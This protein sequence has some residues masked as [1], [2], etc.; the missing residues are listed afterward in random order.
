[1]LFELVKQRVYGASQFVL[2]ELDAEDVGGVDYGCGVD[3][4]TA[5]RRARNVHIDWDNSSEY[6]FDSSCGLGMLLTSIDDLLGAHRRA[7]VSYDRGD[8][9]NST[10]ATDNVSDGQQ[11]QAGWN[12]ANIDKHLAYT[13]DVFYKVKTI[14]YRE[15]QNPVLSVG[16]E[17]AFIPS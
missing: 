2:G 3:V 8:I 1:M 10:L 14:Q 17:G 9:R 11:H 12:G 5:V 13:C 4:W 7:I 15:Y 16:D 6:C